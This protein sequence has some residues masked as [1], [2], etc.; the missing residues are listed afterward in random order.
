M[1]TYCM[2]FLIPTITYSSYWFHFSL[3]AVPHYP[4]VFPE[5]IKKYICDLSNHKFCNGKNDNSYVN[6]IGAAITI[7]QT[8]NKT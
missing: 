8:V 7:G 4:P 2:S 1:L 5:T 6:S 3:V